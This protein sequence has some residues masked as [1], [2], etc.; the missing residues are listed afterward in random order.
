M[1]VPEPHLTAGA[2]GTIACE[3]NRGGAESA[4][5]WRKTPVAMAVAVNSSGAGNETRTRD[6]DLG[7][8]VLYQ[9]SYSRISSRLRIVRAANAKS[10]RHPT[11]REIKIEPPPILRSFPEG[12]D[13][14]APGSAFACREARRSGSGPDRDF[15]YG[16]R[17]NY[18]MIAA[19]RP[20]RSCPR[21]VSRAR[22]SRRPPHDFDR[23]PRRISAGAS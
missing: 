13:S 1:T 18:G 21:P 23:K 8:V 5:P 22:S 6:P 9:L 16:H 3:R 15:G 2:S 14:G 7:K 10:R 19:L 12:R 11:W 4:A 17:G 20:R